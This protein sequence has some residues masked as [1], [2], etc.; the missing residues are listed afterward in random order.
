MAQVM[1]TQG[2]L[3]ELAKI[4]EAYRAVRGAED[5]LRDDIPVIALARNADPQKSLER[6]SQAIEKSRGK[7][8]GHANVAVKSLSTPT[9]KRFGFKPT[10]LAVPLPGEKGMLPES[11]R[12]G[13][14]HAHQ[15][16]DFTLM[17]HDKIVPTAGV[18][19]AV[20]HWFKEGVP[21]SIKRLRRDVSPPVQ[22][23][24]ETPT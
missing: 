7:V 17:H 2:F 8:L 19:A 16:G 5:K 20:S 10:R 13:R 24:S 23:A 21:A 15:M 18:V 1:I 4:A 11:Y 22:Y 14:L 12:K 6:I 9:L 3:D